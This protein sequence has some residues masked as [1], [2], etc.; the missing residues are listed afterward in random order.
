MAHL[1]L[2]IPNEQPNVW[3]A[4]SQAHILPSEPCSHL[5]LSSS[6][7]SRLSPLLFGTFFLPPHSVMLSPLPHFTL[8]A[9][10]FLWI[11]LLFS[12][13]SSY[14]L[15]YSLTYRKWFYVPWVSNIKASERRWNDCFYYSFVDPPPP[16]WLS[17]S[18][19]FKNVIVSDKKMVYLITFLV[20]QESYLECAGWPTSKGLKF[21]VSVKAKLVF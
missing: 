6:L 7:S 2:H 18:W 14:W 17:G 16:P 3:G 11:T 5:S 8:P 19:Y 9:C 1:F 10:F 21:S 12:S 20:H 13:L 4:V 15:F